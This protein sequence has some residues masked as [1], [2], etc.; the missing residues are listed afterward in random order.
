MLI[1][2][3]HCHH[4]LVPFVNNIPPGE[5]T[6]IGFTVSDNCRR[7]N[8]KK[9]QAIHI[10]TCTEHTSINSISH[11][12]LSPPVQGT[13]FTFLSQDKEDDADSTPDERS[14]VGAVEEIKTNP[15]QP[16]AKLPYDS[17]DDD[18]DDD[19]D[20]VDFEGTGFQSGKATSQLDELFFFHPDDPELANRINGKVTLNC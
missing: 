2:I 10:L 3:N 14:Q 6:V 15:W 11:F 19:G 7:I 9:Q 17:S 8:P 4:G 12:P 1:I 13:T 18:D 20:D 16:T 5:C